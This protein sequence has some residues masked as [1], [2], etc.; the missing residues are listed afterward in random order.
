MYNVSE[1]FITALHKEARFERVRGTIGNVS[2]T[3]A[4]VVSMSYSNRCS[5]TADLSLG[6]AY[7]G[8]LEA[9]FVSSQ[10][11]RGS[12]RGVQITVEWGL[13][14]ADSSIEYIPIGV[15]T[16]TEATWSGFGVTIKASDNIAKLDK[17][18]SNA[19]TSGQIYDILTLACQECGLT[20]GLTEEEVEDLPN[21]TE[22]LGVYPNNDISTWRDLVSWVAQTAGA[23][24]YAGRDGKIYLK[25]FSDLSVV[26]SLTET[27]REYQSTFS[28]YATSY[29]GISVVN[30]DDETLSYYSN[31]NVGTDINLGSNPLLQYGTSEVKT[32]IRQAIANSIKNVK[33]TPFVSG[34]LSNMAYDL[35]DLLT[36]TGG[37]AG[38][39]T[40]TCCVMAIDWTSKN[41]TQF[42]GFGSDPSL[43]NGKSKTDKELSGLLRKTAENEVIIHTFENAEEYEL[44]SDPTE[45]ISI[46]FSTI[47]PKIVNLW[48]E[49]ELDIESDPLGDGI[50]EVQA[51]YYLND[52]LISYSPVTTYDNDGYHLMH[53]LYFLDSLPEGSAQKW[54][55]FLKVTGGTATIDRGDIHASLYGQGLAAVGAW[56]GIIDASDN[57][58]LNIIG[59]NAF[60]YTDSASL[61]WYEDSDDE[62]ISENYSL[63]IISDI[64]FGYTDS[65]YLNI[66]SPIYTRI[67]DSEDIRITDDDDVRITDGDPE[68]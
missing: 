12:W 13:V 60:G 55:V 57:Y 23:F 31:G 66:I 43:A 35:G 22:I 45:I 32:R 38:E 52:E 7:I 25:S 2:F 28:D 36:C 50:V 18:C 9:T 41:L 63:N 1:A 26:D 47:K 64:A 16:V 46:R 21:G 42:S 44:D 6:S 11:P 24:V 4:D 58:V 65:V 3:D 15:F 8:Q 54:E 29:A 17:L 68:E 40:L 27:E 33:Y 62:D 67:T 5:D 20:L 53:L 30:I 49:I 34:V 48:H 59:Q 14:L 51:L 61:T 19:Q 10:V 37:I 56:S 39:G